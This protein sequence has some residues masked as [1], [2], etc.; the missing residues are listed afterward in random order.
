MRFE[1]IPLNPPA[2]HAVA[3]AVAPGALPDAVQELLARFVQLAREVE[4]Y[5]EL[6][7][8]ESIYIDYR[9]GSWTAAMVEQFSRETYHYPAAVGLL[10]YAADHAGREVSYR[11]FI[12]Q[13]SWTDRQVRSEL[14]A[15]SKVA[16][17]LFGKK[18]W[19]VR[20]RQ[21]SDGVM[22]YFMPEGIAEWWAQTNRPTRT[23]H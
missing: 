8:G 9:Q 18:A 3:G 2:T 14:G 1:E 17:K 7:A 13:S 5:L 16:R 6:A 19:P 11:D 21:G 4:P 23:P 15:V 20:T 22:R 10:Q 12:A